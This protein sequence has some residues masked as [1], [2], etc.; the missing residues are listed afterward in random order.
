MSSTLLSRCLHS[1]WVILLGLVIQYAYIA[2][3][4]VRY[5]V[6]GRYGTDTIHRFFDSSPFSS[7]EN[8][9]VITELPRT[10][11]PQ[12]LPFANITLFD[13]RSGIYTIIDQ[14][15]AWGGQLG[16]QAQIVNDKVF[17]N[18]LT[19]DTH[20]CKIRPDFILS[21][22]CRRSLSLQ[23]KVYSLETKE[24]QL[25]P[26]SLYH[27]SADGLYTV[28]VDLFQIQHTQKGYGIDWLGNGS[29]SSDRSHLKSAHMKR[30]GI[31]VN[32]LSQ[33]TCTMVASIHDIASSVGLNSSAAPIYG[34]HTKWSSDGARI[35][36]VLRT[37]EEGRTSRRVRVNHLFTLRHTGSI[38]TATQPPLIKYLLSWSSKPF[39]D[40]HSRQLSTGTEQQ[41]DED[42]SKKSWVTLRDGNHPN[43]IAGTHKITMNLQLDA[44]SLPPTPS[45]SLPT[46]AS[47]PA[48][49]LSSLYT[50]FHEMTA[51]FNLFGEV[52]RID[53]GQWRT[54]AM[55][56]DTIPPFAMDQVSSM[57][58]NLT[59][60]QEHLPLFHDHF[61]VISHEALPSAA[62]HPLHPQRNASMSRGDLSTAS[63]QSNVPVAQ[64]TQLQ[65]QQQQL[66]LPKEH[67]VRL[68]V[69][70]TLGFGHPSV[71]PPMK[72]DAASSM[73]GH[74]MKEAEGRWVVTDT[75]PKETSNLRVKLSD[76]S[77]AVSLSSSSASISETPQRTKKI[78]VP[79]LLSR[80]Q[81]QTRSANS[82]VDG[83]HLLL[84][85]LVLV[86]ICLL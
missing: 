78:T 83:V 10:T 56:I 64:S 21:A 58:S 71:R 26:C 37:L 74:R 6:A 48:S 46:P 13:R 73:P 52:Q 76:S 69:V 68:E 81:T 57:G 22:D 12:I 51:T 86:C 47:S 3:A 17:Y 77:A 38:P 23:G 62:T 8:L 16:A 66:S 61:V 67:V 1:K 24:V 63:I 54:I 72:S 36:V 49:L 18:V 55:D 59:A 50:S 79:I 19:Y 44:M 53:R 11:P 29:P 65:L 84:V 35:M 40:R 9:V 82:T 20:L 31:Y 45:P 30:P 7:D 39:L 33:N 42:R 14:T 5:E 85:R 25:L 2:G 43:W 80:Y 28:S 60:Q 41:K 32:N 75:Y 4:S 70:S 15:L 27:V 34:F